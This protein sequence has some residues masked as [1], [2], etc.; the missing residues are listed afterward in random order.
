MSAPDAPVPP[1]VPENSGPVQ[2]PDEVVDRVVAFLR[3]A[4]AS[5]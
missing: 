1:V 2:V 3:R 5:R 4:G